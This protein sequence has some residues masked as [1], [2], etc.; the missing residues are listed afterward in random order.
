MKELAGS[1]VWL[2]A[3]QIFSIAAQHL[4]YYF[5]QS[6][7]AHRIVPSGILDLFVCKNQSIEKQDSVRLTTSSFEA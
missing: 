2:G 4:S 1:F 3:L 7:I 5:S 6:H